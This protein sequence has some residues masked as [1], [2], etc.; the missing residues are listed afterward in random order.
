MMTCRH[1]G[2]HFIMSIIAAANAAANALTVGKEVY[3]ATKRLYDSIKTTK[4]SAAP[5][6]RM[7]SMVRSR[8]SYK[9]SRSH[10]RSYKRKRRSTRRY[11]RG[12]VHPH[13][14]TRF[15]KRSKRMRLYNKG[16]LRLEKKLTTGQYFPAQ[17]T[18]RMNF[19]ASKMCLFS[20]YVNENLSRT[21]VMNSVTY[22]T[23]YGGTFG[24]GG[25]RYYNFW[26]GL[27]RDYAVLGAKIY[28]T[29]KPNL[30][31]I[32]LFGLRSGSGTLDGP[33]TEAQPGFWYVRVRYMRDMA[34]DAGTEYSNVI[35]HPMAD[36][37]ENWW[38]NQRAFCEDPTVT[39]VRDKSA[40]KSKTGYTFGGTTPGVAGT[41]VFPADEPK[42]DIPRI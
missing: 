34:A 9:P 7:R 40:V 6:K 21:F 28:V 13:H 35:G 20:N 10:K 16:K 18:C 31:P 3:G 11:G 37:N 29:I 41:E 38:P 30:Y 4:S 8:R 24:P 33:P 15:H 25:W 32:H 23:N 14:K 17:T 27:Y 19:R 22:F 1:P 5:P 26:T 42:N 12:R 39:W 2:S 36:N